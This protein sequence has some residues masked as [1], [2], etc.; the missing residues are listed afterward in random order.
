MKVP[1]LCS[2]EHYNIA[3]ASQDRHGHHQ[4]ITGATD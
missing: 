2:I 1:W 4:T 3:F